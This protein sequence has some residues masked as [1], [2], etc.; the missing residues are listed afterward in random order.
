[1]L[2]RDLWRLRGQVLAAAVVVACGIAALVAMYST[3][4]S[5]IRTRNSYYADYRFADVFAQL[6]R[7]PQSLVEEIQRIPGVAQVAVRAV[8]SVVLEV[9]G[10]AEP[11]TARLI[12]IC[13]RP[14]RGLNALVVM[15]G[16]VP[17]PAADDEVLA[18]DTFARANGLNPGDRVAAIL[19]G[20][21]QS[22]RLVGT[23]LSPE[24]VYEV[25]PGGLFPDNRRFGVLWMNGDVLEPA[26]GLKGAFNDVSLALAPGANTADVVARLDRLLRVYGGLSAYTRSDQASDRF[27]TDELGEIQVMASAIPLLFL[28]VAVFLLYVILSRLVQMQRADIALLKAFGHSDLSVGTHYIGFAAATVASG[29]ALGLPLGVYLGKV[30]V[31]V[32]RGYFHFP[33]LHW[34]MP[35]SLPVAL[36]FATFLAAALGAL[37]AVRSAV[38][39]APAEAMRP[40]APARFRAG[41]IDRVG[42][43]RCL[44]P[45]MRML[46]RNVTR[47][48][49]KAVL[50][51]FTISLAIALMVVGRFPVDA[52]NTLLRWQFDGVQRADVAAV[53]SEPRS[54]SVL[55]ETARL[56]GVVEVQGFRAVPA[57]IRALYRSKRVEIVSTTP[58]GELRRVIDQEFRRIDPHDDGIVLGQKL[59]QLLA[60]KAGDLITVDVLEGTRPSFQV[61]VTGI[62]DELL[63]LGAYMEHTTLSRRLMEA[64]TVSGVYLRADPAQ[65]EPLLAELKHIPAVAGVSSRGALLASIKETMD[66]SFITFSAILTLFAA[67]IV[68]GMVYNSMRV[69]LSERGHELASLRVLGFTERE[70]AFILLGEQALVALAALPVGLLIGYAICAL[71]VPLFDRENFRLPLTVSPQTLLVAGSAALASAAVCGMIVARR[72]KALDL[73]AVLKTRE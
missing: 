59:A 68:V 48:P 1:M 65:W 23:A 17:N 2:L 42:L 62:V 73:I 49:I 4:Y 51:V 43:V 33:Q 38:A 32:Y 10:L 56:P 63:G 44:A 25:A 18:S 34:M 5:L 35:A 29:L 46:I 70:I 39:L 20:R 3:Y 9:P 14:E 8:R 15:R 53:F 67:A 6:K 12:S 64:D 47:R 55:A 40:E 69:A 50:S 30:F 13:E 60:V 52:V 11:A 31:G 22:L 37:G 57:W 66:R 28:A 19:N 27:L 16:R 61:R 72:L 58:H 54:A 71:L 36:A 7:A 24:Y 41:V 45:A 21:W 26:F